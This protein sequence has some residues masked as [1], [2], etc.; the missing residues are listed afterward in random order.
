MQEIVNILYHQ[1]CVRG[2]MVFRG[3]ISFGEAGTVR[4]FD[5]PRSM[6]NLPLVIEFFAE[7]ALVSQR[8]HT[9]FAS[10]RSLVGPISRLSHRN[11]GL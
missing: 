1:H 3:I 6:V 7:A 4:A 5:I 11:T 9:D 10:L 8:E 2:V